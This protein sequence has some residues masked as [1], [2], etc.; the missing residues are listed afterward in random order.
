MPKQNVISRDEH[1]SIIREILRFI[2]GKGLDNISTSD[3]KHFP[4]YEKFVFSSLGNRVRIISNPPS[5][6][7]IKT[8]LIKWS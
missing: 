5:C 1:N 7:K 8:S 6:L 4:S 2:Y 3:H